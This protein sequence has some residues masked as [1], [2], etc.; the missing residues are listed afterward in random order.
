MAAVITPFLLLYKKA[1]KN[2]NKQKTLTFLYN[3]KLISMIHND[4]T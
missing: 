2:K 3:D 4:D 1:L